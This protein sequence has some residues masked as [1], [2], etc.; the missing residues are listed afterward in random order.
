VVVDHGLVNLLHTIPQPALGAGLNGVEEIG[1]EIAV[2]GNAGF[3]DYLLI[4]D[5]ENGS[6]HAYHESTFGAKEDSGDAGIK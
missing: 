2:G 3:E 1:G 4:A 6:L 5:G